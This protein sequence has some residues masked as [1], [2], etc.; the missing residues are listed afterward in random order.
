MLTLRSIARNGNTARSV[1]IRIN[2]MTKLRQ[3]RYEHFTS[4]FARSWCHEIPSATTVRQIILA[5][6]L[7][8]GSYFPMAF[9]C[10]ARSYALLKAMML[11]G[12][13]ELEYA[14]YHA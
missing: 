1:P 10:V 9:V 8:S 11:S 5:V 7:T 12:T 13:F 6:V 14:P 2:P 4:P 3:A